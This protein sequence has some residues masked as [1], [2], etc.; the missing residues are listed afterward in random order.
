M[1]AGNEKD[2]CPFVFVLNE[3]ILNSLVSES[4]RSCREGMPMVNSSNRY[5]GPGPLMTEKHK[6]IIY[7][8][9]VGSQ[10]SERRR[11]ET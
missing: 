8:L 2:L 1:A 11:G 4:E 10:C 9:G 7:S 3:G 5:S 6:L